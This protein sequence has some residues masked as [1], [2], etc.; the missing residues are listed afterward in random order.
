M[1]P[2]CTASA[3][4]TAPSSTA[5][6]SRSAEPNFPTGVLI[7]ETMTERAM[8]TAFE[9]QCKVGRGRGEDWRARGGGHGAVGY[10][11]RAARALDRCP[12]PRARDQYD[13]RRAVDGVLARAHARRHAPAL[14]RGLA[15]GR[16]RG[17]HA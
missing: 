11:G 8:W 14:Q 12:G 16:S 2:R 4:A 7:A 3:M 1:P 10:R 6:R 5:E 13:C 9:P 15:H 17:R